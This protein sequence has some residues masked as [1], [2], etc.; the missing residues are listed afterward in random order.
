MNLITSL[1]KEITMS[2]KKSYNYLAL[3]GAPVDDME[4][5][6]TFGLSPDSAYSNK[7]NEDMLQYN[8]NKAVEEGLEPDKAAEIKKN[9]E[10]DIREL[11]AKNGMLK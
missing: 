8:Y 9:A 3:R 5:V 2:D 11:L 4:Y 10:R 6:E 1:P 7:I